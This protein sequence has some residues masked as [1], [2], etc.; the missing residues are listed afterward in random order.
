METQVV[1]ECNNLSGN[2][3]SIINTYSNTDTTSQVCT[4]C[5]NSN[6]PKQLNSVMTDFITYS[7]PLLTRNK[8]FDFWLGELKSSNIPI[9]EFTSYFVKVKNTY[10]PGTLLV[11]KIPWFYLN[12]DSCKCDARI[13]LMND[14]G[15]YT[16]ANNL[17]LILSWIQEACVRENKDYSTTYL[18]NVIAFSIIKSHL[19]VNS[20]CRSN[21]YIAHSLKDLLVVLLKK[22][23]EIDT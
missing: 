3:C 11:K 14:W 8:W 12:D 19:L 23:L 15:P 13:A 6:R 4:A 9:E 10:G 1:V 7:D 18:F 5:I 2:K 16:S 20:K 22:Y 17:L 21:S